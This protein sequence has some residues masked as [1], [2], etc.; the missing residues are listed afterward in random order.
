[1]ADPLGPTGRRNRFYVTEAPTATNNRSDWDAIVGYSLE[2]VVRRVICGCAG[3]TI[4]NQRLCWPL[5]MFSITVFLFNLCKRAAD[6][7]LMVPPS[8]NRC[9]DRSLDSHLKHRCLAFMPVRASESIRDAF[10]ERYRTTWPNGDW[11]WSQVLQI[12][13]LLLLMPR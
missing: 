10:E 7:A 8:F 5:F 12:L 9:N 13:M 4:H 3:V 6:R 2:W 1:M 11:V